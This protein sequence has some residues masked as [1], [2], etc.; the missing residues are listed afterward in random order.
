MN[1]RYDGFGLSNKCLLSLSA[2]GVGRVF[3]P[4]DLNGALVRRRAMAQWFRNG[5][6]FVAYKDPVRVYRLQST[7]GLA[8][9]G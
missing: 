4:T 3:I 8:S 9:N 2:L 5:V 6:S 7:V 1:W